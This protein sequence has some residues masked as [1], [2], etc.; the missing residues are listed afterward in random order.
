[1]EAMAVDIGLVSDQLV[2]ACQIL[3]PQLRE[4]LDEPI[5]RRV[6]IASDMGESIE[7]LGYGSAGASTRS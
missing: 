7:R 5:Q 2:Q 3:R 6:H 4:A 1:M